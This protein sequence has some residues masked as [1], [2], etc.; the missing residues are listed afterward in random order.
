MSK[1]KCEFK[2]LLYYDVIPLEVGRFL[3]TIIFYHLQKWNGQEEYNL[4]QISEY[5]LEGVTI[6]Q[7]DYRFLGT[8]RLA[9]CPGC[10]RHPR[11][12]RVCGPEQWPS[13]SARPNRNFRNLDH[14][15]RKW[16]SCYQSRSSLSTRLNNGF[17][18]LVFIHK[19]ENS[20]FLFKKVLIIENVNKPGYRQLKKNRSNFQLE[21]ILISFSVQYDA[22]LIR[23]LVVKIPCIHMICM[24]V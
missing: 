4:R 7:S 13:C 11:R 16:R 17:V 12:T 18:T 23:D 22:A 19:N 15:I 3:L 5:W 2:Y 14:V 9:P 8:A 24:I 1:R 6:V 20:T 10:E 21:M